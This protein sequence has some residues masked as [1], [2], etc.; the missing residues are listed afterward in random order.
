MPCQCML[1]DVYVQGVN[2]MLCSASHVL[3]F[4][5]ADGV[6]QNTIGGSSKLS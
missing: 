4:T 5:P 2:V 3:L 6:M 1:A